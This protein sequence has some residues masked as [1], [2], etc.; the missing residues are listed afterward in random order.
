MT[1][2]DAA[3]M[4]EVERAKADIAGDPTLSMWG[5]MKAT[6]ALD[7]AAARQPDGGPLVT[8]EDIVHGAIGAGL[9]YGV[10]AAVGSFLG[11]SPET[12]STL[13]TLGAG[14]GTLLNTGVIG[15]SKKTADEFRAVEERDIR[16]AVRLGFVKAAHETG[17]LQ[18]PRYLKKA[19][20]EINP[21]MFT[22]PMKAL[23][24]VTSTAGSAA[25]A[26]GAAIF[27]DDEADEKISK[28]ML[29]KRLMERQADQL[30]QQRRNR[31]IAGVLAKRS[32]GAPA[33]TTRY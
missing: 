9:G 8:V 31:I 23:S 22:A 6:E 30:R 29:E 33:N 26:A 18:H 27:G 32:G 2:Q 19:F 28:M 24:N 12:R 10:G 4:V 21:E 11:F 15:M 7:A 16:N 20:I 25:G 17:L 3:A 13:K 1:I 14:L 5:R